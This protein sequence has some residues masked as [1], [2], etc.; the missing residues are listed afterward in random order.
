[1][2]GRE[3]KE[4]VEWCQEVGKCLIE[5]LIDLGLDR[6]QIEF[7]FSTRVREVV[8]E[9]NFFQVEDLVNEITD[10]LKDYLRAH[11]SMVYVTS[12]GKE[13]PYDKVVRD[14]LLGVSDSWQLVSELYRNKYIVFDEGQIRFTEKGDILSTSLKDAVRKWP[15]ED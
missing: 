13:F 15:Y 4:K 11:Y 3:K 5:E 6:G 2:T 10:E 12:Y 9:E 1:M 8:P 14:F 7:W